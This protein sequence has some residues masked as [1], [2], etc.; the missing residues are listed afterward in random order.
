MTFIHARNA[1]CGILLL[2]ALGTKASAD[3]F[4]GP[5][6]GWANVTSYG[7][8]GSD[9]SDDTIAIQNAL[10]DL[11]TT[12]HS[13]TLYIPAGT[14]RISST[15]TMSSREGVAIVGQD[16]ANTIIKWVGASA[17]ATFGAMMAV[18]GVWFSR[19][20][21]ITW[22]G[23]NIATTAW[24]D[25]WDG[26]NWY[27][28]THNEHADEV[29]K[30]V[31]F[32]IRA[33]QRPQIPGAGPNTGDAET[34]VLRCKFLSCT[35]AGISIQD[36][37]A[38]D[39]FLWNCTFDHC[40][41][42]ATNNP[43]ADGAGNF[44]VYNS[45]FRYSSVA[46]VSMSNTGYFSMRGNYS[47]GSKQFFVGGWQG[48]NAAQITLQKNTILDTT[49]AAAVDVSNAGPVMLIDNVIRAAAGQ[50]GPQVKVGV[51]YNQ[52]DTISVGNKY[53]NTGPISAGG[54]IR[55]VSDTVVNRTTITATE[56]TMPGAL[57]NNNRHIFEIA[58]TGTGADIQTAINSAV[59]SYNGQRAVVH[60]QK[61][62]HSIASTIQIPANSDVQLVGDG[63]APTYT[64]NLKWT[65]PAGGTV[66][67]INSPSRATLRDLQV[68]TDG[69]T[70]GIQTYVGDVAGDRIFAEQGEVGGN[71]TAGILSNGLSN[72]LVELRDF[73]HG[74]S[75][76]NSI[77][78]VGGSGSGRVNIFGGCDTNC[79]GNSYNVSSNGRLLVED[80]WYEA[81]P[82]SGLAPNFLNLTGSGTFTLQGGQV[83]AQTNTT[84]P[85][86]NFNG[87]T[88]TASLIGLSVAANYGSQGPSKAVIQSSTGSG[89]NIMIMGVT[90]D[91]TNWFTNN[92][93]TAQV[94]FINNR[95]PDASNAIVQ[96]ADA[97]NRKTD[98]TFLT[99]CL[100]QV[101]AEYPSAAPLA[102][103]PAGTS[104]IR[105]YRM[106]STS[107]DNAVSPSAY[108]IRID[109]LVTP[110]DL[111]VQSIS[112][113]PANPTTGQSATFKCV[114]KNQGGTATSAGTIIGVSWWVDGT[115]VNWEDTDTASLAPGATRTETATGGPASISTWTATAGTHT[116]MAWVDDVNRI[117]E[118]NESNN[119][120]SATMTVTAASAAPIGS[121]ISLKAMS[122]SCFVSAYNPGTTPL[123][124]DRTSV[125]AWEQFLV[126]DAG[127][128]NV[129]LKSPV[130][131]KYVTAGSSPLIAGQT[132]PGLA[133]TF[134]LITQGTGLVALQA[135]VNSK[136]VSAVNTTTPLIADHTTIT[137]SEQFQW[138]AY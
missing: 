108:N 97:G 18:N 134:K 102:A 39:W 117:A 26:N 63:F 17:P 131:N 85:V 57:A 123:I 76:G 69:A 3:E 1:A 109:K 45:V 81:H 128:G 103:T 64:T 41:R 8:N 86:F 106:R 56:P 70:T 5:L 32:G 74:G 60:I 77:M 34:A 44:H 58:P 66:M 115:Q 107:G 95:A 24:H 88:G 11:G 83:S 31:G 13:N 82:P 29:F 130:N 84:T 126:V 113:T 91:N 6:A 92:S 98:D 118:S 114:V 38:L 12:G 47:I 105:F 2:A 121:T 36:P 35:T 125:G 7:A 137:T 21:R 71:T 104:D 53:T 75:N 100:A 4:I 42:G 127:S 37:N 87:F 135:M 16:P 99:Q 19:Y 55:A 9:S 112:W 50:T 122:D 43:P 96:T 10:N 73:Y 136:Y 62:T 65:G 54:R 110:A 94:A 40:A 68:I 78:V 33:G 46:D 138:L 61:G 48:N 132:T 27:F 79:P 15:L 23:N 129:Y 67:V 116:I 28:P 72:T 20:G 49:Q 14:Y 101:R 59:A 25:Y 51:G 80:M 89:A 119:Q 93:T 22:D 52:E 120:T 124:A 90:G 111:V 133:E 30:N